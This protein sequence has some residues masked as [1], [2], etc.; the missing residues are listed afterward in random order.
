M[1]SINILSLFISTPTATTR[2]NNIVMDSRGIIGDKFYGKSQCRAVLIASFGA[3]SLMRQNDIIAP[4]GALGENILVDFDTNRLKP[5]D[6]LSIGDAKLQITQ[7]CTI[8]DHLSYI[9]QVV[10]ALLKN[11]RGI[12]AKVIKNG[13]I[14]IHSKMTVYKDITS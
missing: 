4:F 7:N 12:F 5:N 9:D 3:Y 2:Q 6:R 1:K 11:D 13:T 8:C 10:P 14:S